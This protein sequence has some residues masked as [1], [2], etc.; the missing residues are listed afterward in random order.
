MSFLEGNSAFIKLHSEFVN[1]K[2]SVRTIVEKNIWNWTT[3][4]FSSNLNKI[5]ADAS[6]SLD[7]VLLRILKPYN[8]L[9]MNW[10]QN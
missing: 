1:T 10:P 7:H 4:H 5:T 9:W 6:F 3:E 2:D 8:Q